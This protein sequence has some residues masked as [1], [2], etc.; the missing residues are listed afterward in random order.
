MR[1]P[2]DA[3]INKTSDNPNKFIRITF[4]PDLKMDKFDDDLVSFFKRHAYDVAVSTG[5][6]IDATILNEFATDTHSCSYALFNHFVHCFNNQHKMIKEFPL[7]DVIFCS[8]EAFN[9]QISRIDTLMFRYLP[10]LSGKF[11]SM[12]NDVL[13]N[14]VFEA[15]TKSNHACTLKKQKYIELV[16][17][18]CSTN[19]TS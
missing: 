13:R 7:S 3:I 19:K 11:D 4:T 2:Q 6:K 9:Q 12:L 1:D 5:C 14:H 16:T 8:I 18:L 15:K 17:A 10:A